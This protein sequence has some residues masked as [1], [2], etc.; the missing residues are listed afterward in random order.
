MKC[1][2]FIWESWQSNNEIL[3]T[4]TPFHFHLKRLF[5]KDMFNIPLRYG[6]CLFLSMLIFMLFL[7]NIFKTYAI[8]KNESKWL[9][10]R[11]FTELNMTKD[12]RSIEISM[13]ISLSI[14]LGF[15]VLLFTLVQLNVLVYTKSLVLKFRRG[16]YVFKLKDVYSYDGINLIASFVANTFISL[17]VFFLF[18]FCLITPI[19]FKEFWMI[20]WAL[21]DRWLMQV[22]LVLFN[23]AMETVLAGV[24]TDGFHIR[25]R[26]CY[27]IYELYTMIMGFIVSLVLGAMRYALLVFFVIISLF[28]VD[29]SIIPV[30][31]TKMFH[32]N[33]DSVNY[34]FRAFI[35]SYYH[36][37][38]P[39]VH[40]FALMMQ[41]G[42]FKRKERA[43]VS[44]Q[45]LEA[46]PEVK[47]NS[48]NR[49]NQST[50]E[51]AFKVIERLPLSE[52]DRI[53]DRLD[54]G[55]GF[56]RPNEEVLKRRKSRKVNRRIAAKWQLCVFL[57]MNPSLMQYRVS[58]QSDSRNLDRKGNNFYNKDL[59]YQDNVYGVELGH[60]TTRKD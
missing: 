52:I 22:V 42:L 39:I 24:F 41:A 49:Q 43:R 14:S 31:V 45:D 16:E 18:G 56:D 15:F 1:N 13:N 3:E 26:F 19:C 44:F 5:L 17:Y 32:F 50:Q 60:A 11:L 8:L 30:W 37:N 12:I 36:H 40:T 38:N 27:Q 57:A 54:M 10:D 53:G 46:G 33:F 48:H 34:R 23:G 51:I 7:V 4:M 20:L 6:I 29:S 2:R 35:K 28:R 55:E 59:E 47:K 21:R 25:F 58:D 9:K